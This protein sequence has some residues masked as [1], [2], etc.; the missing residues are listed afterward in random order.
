M[1]DY[2]LDPS[3]R[4]LVWT[5]MGISALDSHIIYCTGCYICMFTLGDVGLVIVMHCLSDFGFPHTD[6]SK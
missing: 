1:A 5:W 2:S 4:G 3:H 6:M